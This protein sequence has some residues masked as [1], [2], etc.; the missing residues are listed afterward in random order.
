MRRQKTQ[1][2]GEALVDYMRETGLEQ[3]LLVQKVPSL[4]RSVMGDMVAVLTRKIEVKDGVLFVYLNSAA[5]KA[6][7]FECRYELVAKMNE[8]LGSP[9]IKDVRLLG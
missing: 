6:Q 2:L 7:L 8:A 1:S 5:L 9:L 4:W 3:P